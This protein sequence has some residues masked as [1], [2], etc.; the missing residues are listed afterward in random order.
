[1]LVAPGD[2]AWTGFNNQPE[3][4]FFVK[5]NKS[6]GNSRL[7]HFLLRVTACSYLS[8]VSWPIRGSRISSWPIRGRPWLGTSTCDWLYQI[9]HSL[10]YQDQGRQHLQEKR[11]DNSGSAMFGASAGDRVHLCLSQFELPGLGGITHLY[12]YYALHTY[13]YHPYYFIYNWI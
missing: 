11:S 9:Y 12:S 10:S 13:D 8:F 6:S 4:L 7:W 2:S 1:M 5:I 3:Y